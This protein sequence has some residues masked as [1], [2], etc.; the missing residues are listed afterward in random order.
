[1]RRGGGGGGE[2]RILV[3]YI[4]DARYLVHCQ[5]YIFQ[6]LRGEKWINL[7]QIEKTQPQ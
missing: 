6:S 3:S 5:S 7:C 4:W 1:M 2:T